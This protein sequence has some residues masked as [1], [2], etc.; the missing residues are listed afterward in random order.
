[1]GFIGTAPRRL[2]LRRAVL[3][4]R[5][6]CATLGDMQLTLNVLDALTPARGA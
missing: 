2:A 4:E 1:M 5:R 3:P 6:A